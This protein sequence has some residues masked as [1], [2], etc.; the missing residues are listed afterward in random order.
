[1]VG[2]VLALRRPPFPLVVI[3]AVAT[4]ALLRLCGVA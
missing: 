1:M 4:T 3:A 2:G